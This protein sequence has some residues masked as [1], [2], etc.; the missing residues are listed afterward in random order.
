MVV[1]GSVALQ[2]AQNVVTK[3]R[4]LTGAKRTKTEKNKGRYTKPETSHD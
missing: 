2:I 4:S 1:G 3:Q